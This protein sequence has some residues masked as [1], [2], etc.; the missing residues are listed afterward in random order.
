VFALALAAALPR[1]IAARELTAQQQQ[2]LRENFAL[3]V[4]KLKGPYAENV[5][6]CKDGTRIPVR[7]ASGQIGV[8]CKDPQFCAAFRAP[9]ADKVASHGVYLANVFSRDLYLWDSFPDHNDLVC[10]YIVEKYFVDTNPRHKLSQLRAFGGLSGSE[11]EAPAATQMYERYLAAP[12]FDEARHFVLAY[13]LQRRFFVLDDVVQRE[14]VRTLAVNVNQTDPKFKP[15]RNEVHNQ[16]SASII[17]RLEEYGKALP[18]GMGRT[19]LDRLIVELGRLTIVDDAAVIGQVHGIEDVELRDKLRAQLP[20]ETAGSLE[21]VMAFGKI[22]ALTRRYVADR[23]VSAADHR[24]LIDVDIA[25]AAGVQ[26]RGR[27][28][29][30]SGEQ[31]TVRQRLQLLSALTNAAY[32]AGLL[33][34]SERAAAAAAIDEMLAQQQQPRA[35]FAERLRVVHRVPELAQANAAAAFADVAPAWNLVLPATAGVGNDVVLASPVSLYA[36]AARP[37]DDV[38]SGGQP[39]DVIS[40]D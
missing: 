21:T 32:G 25:A 26:R 9:W 13:E 12:E 20:A 35:R 27:A 17:P 31:L 18:P 16:M 30:G 11:Y 22:M 1:P 34:E 2:D 3:C 8:G 4:S 19:Q 15:L 39:T 36:E 37:L 40:I 24:R 10:G 14:K 33:T 23:K 28:L 38:A 6:V 5:C 29:L 7:S